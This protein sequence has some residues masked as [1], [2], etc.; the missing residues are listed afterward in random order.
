MTGFALAAIAGVAA[1][2]AI[3]AAAT[4]GVTLTVEDHSRAPVQTQPAA[5]SLSVPYPVQYGDRCWRGHC[6]PWP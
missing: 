4:V 2:L 1:G 5:R 3:G 6:I